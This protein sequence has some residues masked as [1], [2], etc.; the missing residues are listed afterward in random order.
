MPK[1]TARGVATAR[2][3]RHGDGAG[4]W[5]E[6]SPT[7][8][9]RWVYR[10]SF[11][12]RVTEM[13]L[14]SAA[15]MTLAEA[16]IAASGARK[17]V[18]SGVN[19][20]E[21]R[22]KA[23]EP[24]PSTPT[25]GECARALIASKENGWRNAKHRAQWRMT[26]ATYAKP[27]WNWP[28]DSIDVSGVLECLQPIW[29][30]KPET[31]SRLRG[32]IEVV[33]D[34]ARVKGLRS[35]ENPARWKGNLD[36]ILPRAKKLSRGHHAAMAYCDVPGFLARLGERQSIA[37]MALE[38]LILTATRTGEALG[39]TWNE[40]DVA[41]KVWTVAAGRT[42]SG[43]EHRVPLS[44]PA[45]A[46]LER[47]AEAKTGEFIF[48]GQRAGKPLSNMSLEMVLRRMKIDATVHGFRSAFIDWAGDCTHYPR[49]LAEAALAHI[50][51][52]TTER[53]Y[54]RS[55]ALEKRRK[56]MDEWAGYISKPGKKS[57]TI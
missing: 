18:A 9:R 21:E 10:F 20:I 53:A 24:L 27:I 50:A 28:V 37:A 19:P 42:K 44:R 16:R 8:N 31:A 30:A 52:D 15:T 1:L 51:G 47:L 5:L 4:L 49:E 17:L 3:G 38:F 7:G 35:G 40:T 23:K 14:G 46:I 41:A 34:S 2:R 55:D 54:R 43:R 29:S 33:L 57:E 25:F 22:R 12:K 36:H 45:I 56:L 26:L 6:V 48:P 39:A 32:R 13:S 11:S